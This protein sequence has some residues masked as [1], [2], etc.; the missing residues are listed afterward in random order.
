MLERI[1]KSKPFIKKLREGEL[2][3]YVDHF[4]AYLIDQGYKRQDLRSRFAVISDLSV[5]LSDQ[6]LGLGGLSERQLC[7]FI[8][9]RKKHTGGSANFIRRGDGKTLSLLVNIL[10][11]KEI[12]PKPISS[13]PENESVENF[14]HDYA[15]YLET[16]KGLCA[17]TVKRNSDVIR[18]FLLNLLGTCTFYP[19]NITRHSVLAYI[20]YCRKRFSSKNTQLIASV[21]RSF[22][23]HLFMQGVIAVKL[24]TCIPS[25]P[26]WRA[27]HL[28]EFLTQPQVKRLLNTCDRR[29]IKGLRNYAILLLI[30]RLGL[31]ASEVLY[32]SLDDINWQQ[33]E[34]EICG[35]RGK[36][37]LLP[38]PSDVGE[39]LTAY[40]RRARPNVEIRQVF[41]RT[42]APYR[43]LRNPS[44]I[45]S[46]VN[47]ALLAAGLNPQQHGAHLLRYT[48]ATESLRNG[49]T[50]FEIGDLLG[51]SSVDTTALYTKVDIE[52]LK[53]LSQPWPVI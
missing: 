19:Q 18:R 41:I 14:I 29:T 7:K 20:T 27:A 49:A 52:R 37:R 35:K 10:R 17:S 26:A 34:I 5:W 9:Y 47:R 30:V 38:L 12:V 51:H 16:E 36:H 50:L 48:A 40:L 46:I 31:R 13:A 33:G 2:G 24:A 44:N 43:G 6:K 3:K 15:Q 53:Q 22:L 23:N 21:L 32:L 25:L 45:S 11:S 28:P 42:R 8:E 4:A 1:Y 39:A